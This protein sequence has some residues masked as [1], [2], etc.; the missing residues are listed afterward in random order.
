MLKSLKHEKGQGATE[1][2]II[3]A[4][5]VAAVVVF[6]PWVRNALTSKGAAIS[7]QITSA[8]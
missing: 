7:S 6:G 4:I 2:I 8:S 1:Y 3:V 5:I